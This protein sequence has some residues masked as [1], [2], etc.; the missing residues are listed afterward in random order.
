M[1]ALASL[2]TVPHAL[3]RSGRR[4]GTQCAFDGR[5][6]GEPCGWHV[7]LSRRSGD[8]VT[9]AH[10]GTVTRSSAWTSSFDEPLR[11][12]RRS[13]LHGER[14]AKRTHANAVASDGRPRSPCW[15]RL[16]SLAL[17]RQTTGSPTT[18]G[19]ALAPMD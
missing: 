2:N 8:G 9:L 17:H 4:R 19:G 14:P 7:Y 16:P 11:G 10:P 3:D 1:E 15:L 6:E 5:A 13:Y 18:I 12:T